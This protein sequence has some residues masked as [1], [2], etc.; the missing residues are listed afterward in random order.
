MTCTSV[1]LWIGL[2][3]EHV[4]VGLGLKSGLVLLRHRIP[5]MMSFHPWT[6][7]YLRHLSV[8]RMIEEAQYASL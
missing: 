4:W 2:W 7:R 8:R 1:E 3:W 5:A 6:V